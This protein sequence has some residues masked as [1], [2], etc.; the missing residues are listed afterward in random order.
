MNI[1]S[2]TQIHIVYNNGIKQICLHP[3]KPLELIKEKVSSHIQRSD[4]A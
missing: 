1:I 2:E 3:L 4:I